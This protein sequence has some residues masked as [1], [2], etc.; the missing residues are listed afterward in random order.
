MKRLPI[1]LLITTLAVA[2]FLTSAPLRAQSGNQWQLDF[3]N[4][5]E[6]FGAPSYRQFSNAINFNWGEGAPGPGM[7][8][9]FWTAR[10]TSDAYFYAGTYAFTVLADDEFVLTIDNTVYYDTRGAAQS[11]KQI[12]FTVNMIQ[13]THRVQLDFREIFSTAY[14]FLTWAYVKPEPPPTAVLPPPIVTVPP[15]IV[16]VPPVVVGTPT[17]VPPPSLQNRFGDFTPC[18]IQ[19][20]HQANCFQ[21]DG[22]WDSPNLGSIQMEPP[23]LW[24]ELCPADQ[25]ALK[26][27]Y[28]DPVVRTAKC[29]KSGAGWFPT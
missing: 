19:N 12:T 22:A 24:W 21:S 18:L 14:V 16:T 10:M 1:F 7:Q 8:V 9:D 26:T 2:G 15:P 20:M 28:P 11:G 3:Y 29:S 13:G 4:N 17:P 25:V 6:W 5:P 23:I 27:F